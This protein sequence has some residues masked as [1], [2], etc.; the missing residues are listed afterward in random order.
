MKKALSKSAP[1]INIQYILTNITSY[2]KQL[3]GNLVVHGYIHYRVSSLPI[4]K[5]ADVIA[6]GYVAK[7]HDQAYKLYTVTP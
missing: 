7:V 4:L 1:I 6:T 2:H 5:A 3:Q